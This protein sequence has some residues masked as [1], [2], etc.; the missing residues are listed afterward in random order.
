MGDVVWIRY[1]DTQGAALEAPAI[2]MRADGTEVSAMVLSP[3]H[4]L[5][6]LLA[7]YSVTPM[8]A[9]TTWRWPVYET[10]DLEL[11]LPGETPIAAEA[12]GDLE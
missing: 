3:V 11:P 6:P 2:V 1:T 4:G 9:L 8:G 12:E 7:D 5:V 10:E